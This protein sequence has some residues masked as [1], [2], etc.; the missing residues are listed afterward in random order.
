MARTVFLMEFRE[1]FVQQFKQALQKTKYSLIGTAEEGGETVSQLAAMKDPPEI[2][3][4]SLMVDNGTDGVA[5]I[6]EIRKRKLPIKAIITY[7]IDSKMR[8]VQ[9]LK[10]GAVDRLRKPFEAE[11]V[12]KKL[13][14]V[15]LLKDI[16]GG[17]VMFRSSIRLDKPIPVTF[18]KNSFFAKKNNGRTLDISIEGCKLQSNVPFERKAMLKIWLELPKLEKPVKVIGQVM[19][20]THNKLHSTY[21]AGIAFKKMSEEVN[22]TLRMYI[23][24]EAEKL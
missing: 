16:D 10:A 2:A 19:N 5:T 11:E 7:T 13:T 1:E 4:I 24:D 12:E 15:H 21:E 6:K 3:V 23:M 9:A 14:K 20:V 8:L 17:G 18:A 22:E